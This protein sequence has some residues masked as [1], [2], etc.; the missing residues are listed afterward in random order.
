[1]KLWK[2]FIRTMKIMEKRWVLYVIAIFFMSTG[3]AMFSVM[4]SLL[5]D[6][7]QT[8]NSSQMIYVIIGNVIVGFISLLVYRVSAIAYN[9]E[10]KRAYGNLCKSIFHHEVRLPYSYYEKHHSGEFIS[11]LSYD[12]EKTGSI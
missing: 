2:L 3:G 7:A 10:A 12:L 8:G 9:V 1:M 11:K 6:A 4:T 5:I